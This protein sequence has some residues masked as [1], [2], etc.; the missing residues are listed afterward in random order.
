MASDTVPDVDEDERQAVHRVE[1]G[2]EWLRRAHGALVEFHHATGHAMDHFAAAE[3]QLREE[4]YG[5]LADRLQEDCLP[6][7]VLSDGR[8]SYAVLEDFEEEFMTEMTAFERAV[9]EAAT[10]GQR[11]VAER[12]QE[13]AWKDRASDGDGEAADAVGRG[14]GQ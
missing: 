4:G 12:A 7:G 9:R 10:G 5:D 1:L 3:D 2:I 11:H 13:A 8:W 14:S 6:R